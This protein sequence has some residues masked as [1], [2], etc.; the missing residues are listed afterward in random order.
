MK[1][2]MITLYEEVPEGIVWGR[3]DH[4]ESLGTGSPDGPPSQQC[5]IAIIC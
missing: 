5:T 2:S 1:R 4:R 3:G